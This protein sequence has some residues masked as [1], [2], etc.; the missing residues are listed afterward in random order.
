MRYDNS[1]FFLF[2]SNS[3]ILLINAFS[4]GDVVNN[5]ISPKISTM[6]LSINAPIKPSINPKNN[7]I[8]PTK[9]IKPISTE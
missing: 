5:E 3:L 6:K 1:I 8:R 2:S 4:S 9:I 7:K